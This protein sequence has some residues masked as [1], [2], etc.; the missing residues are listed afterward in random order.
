MDNDDGADSALLGRLARTLNG[1]RP[2]YWAALLGLLLTLPSLDLG[3]MADD[4]LLRANLLRDPRLPELQTATWDA[5]H[6]FPPPARGT[7]GIDQ[8]YGVWWAAI[9]GYA[10]HL[11]PLAALSHGLELQLWPQQPWLMHLQSA[12][13]YAALCG[14]AAALFRRLMGGWAAG[15]AVL[16]YTA[17]YTHGMAAAWIANRNA[18]M[19][20][21]LG[22]AALLLHHR[23]RLHG[24]RP[25]A[26]A[27]P[28]LLAAGLGAGEVALATA[29]FLVAHVATLES[30]NLAQRLRSLAPYLGVGGVWL[31][32]Y[33]AGEF[34][35]HGSG[36]YLQPSSLAYV[37]A[38]PTHL[39]L[40]LGSELGGAG[41]DLW[42][43]VE[44]GP[45][46]GL[47]AVA[48]LAL[49]T[50]VVALWPI[51]KR[52]ANARFLALGALLSALP[53]CATCPSSRLALVPGFGLVGLAA[54]AVAEWR[55]SPAGQRRRVQ[56]VF[57]V[58][59]G[60]MHLLLSPL[61]FLVMVRQSPATEAGIAALVRQIPNEPAVSR[62]RL[63]IV[64]LP[65]VLY[66]LYLRA[67]LAGQG[68]MRAVPQGT[69]VLGLGTHDLTL[70]RRDP[71]TVVV[72][73]PAGFYGQDFSLLLRQADAPMAVGEQVATATA[74]AKVLAARDGVPTEVEFRF[75]VPLEDASLRWVAW[76][77]D[78][79]LPFAVPAVGAT[80]QLPAQVHPLMQPPRGGR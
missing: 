3:W 45:R 59:A 66:T 9:D 63:I 65:D 1:P 7:A 37:Q 50:A 20:A 22:L 38:L 2:W 10:R 36:L 75:G 47:A 42:P 76:H 6:F 51:L 28:L 69:Y 58:W 44:L 57:A 35:A 53:L 56:A 61:L 54:M 55:A 72:R 29:A 15:L 18:L 34:G 78:S 46:L 17:D 77:G 21:T 14:V 80:A 67:A 12:L 64:N 19:A 33:L 31:A 49:L 71:Q 25:A 43:L 26:V 40:L 74:T 32:A 48:A 70:T 79:L 8:G 52:Q 13:W 4:H 39:L 16:F 60:G 73:D 11:R 5:F 41:P 27:A 68:Q 62:Q 24:D 30:G 23:A